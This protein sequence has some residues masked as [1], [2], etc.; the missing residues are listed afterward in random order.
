M[1]NNADEKK[2]KPFWFDGNKA[3]GQIDSEEDFKR[4]LSFYPDA[5]EAKIHD[6]S[7][8]GKRPS[9]PSFGFRMEHIGGSI[10]LGE[11]MKA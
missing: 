2:W 11:W 8:D 6:A 7:N 5:L 10:T 3:W 9:G 1:E 4:I